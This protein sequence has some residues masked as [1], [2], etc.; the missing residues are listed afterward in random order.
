MGVYCNGDGEATF[1]DNKPTQAE[2]EEWANG[3]AWSFLD[4]YGECVEMYFDGKDDELDELDDD[5]RDFAEHF[6]PDEFVIYFVNEYGNKWRYRL[7]NG[8]VVCEN[9]IGIYEGAEPSDEAVEAI[10]KSLEGYLAEYDCVL[11]TPMVQGEQDY[12]EIKAKIKEWFCAAI[13]TL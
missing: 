7:V 1:F 11:P 4:R 5:I 12:K 6:H 9:Q 3:S 2:L 8:S 13:R 10:L